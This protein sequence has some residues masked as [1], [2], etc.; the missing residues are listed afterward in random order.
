M[1][2]AAETVMFTIRDSCGRS[3]DLK[4]DEGRLRGQHGYMRMVALRGVE[5]TALRIQWPK[6]HS[7]PKL[8]EAVEDKRLSDIAKPY[9]D[10]EGY[11]GGQTKTE[12]ICNFI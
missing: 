4:T 6:S 8:E 12:V 10:K 11:V 7:K 5:G 2:S 9:K 3:L 1:Q